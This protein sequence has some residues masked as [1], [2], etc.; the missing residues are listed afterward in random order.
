MSK[1]D[2][3]YLV[4]D[5]IVELA[6]DELVETSQNKNIIE[7]LLAS[8]KTDE[9]RNDIAAA[10]KRIRERKINDIIDEK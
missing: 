2:E 3:F 7:E 8:A 5:R 9:I 4:Y 10:I 6:M 1:D